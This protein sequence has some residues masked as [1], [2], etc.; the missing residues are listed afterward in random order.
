M[1][2][3]TAI[4][5]A[6][7]HR[8]GTSALA[9]ALN[10]LGIP[11]GSRLLESGP[12]N[13]KGYWEHR[14]IVV[15]HERLLAA[16]G[17]RWDDVRAL[18][19]GWLSS[20]PARRAAAAIT[21]IIERDFAGIPLWAV[22]DPRL[23]RVLPLWFEVLDK[24]GTRPMVLFMVRDP[25]EVSASIA[26]RNLWA[27]PIGEILWLRYVTES[28]EHSHRVP[29]S[30]VT[31]DALLADPAV[32]LS[33]VLSE[34]GLRPKATDS[35]ANESLGQ[36]VDIADRHHVHLNAA[37]PCTRFGIIAKRVYDLLVEVAQDR[38]DWSAVTRA[39]AGF[40]REWQAQHEV[41]EAFGGMAA[42][43]HTDFQ[44]AEVRIARLE[45]DLTAQI[46]WSD[47]AKTAHEAMQAENAELS[48][49][50]TAQIRW[51]EEAQARQEA[52]H[53]ENAELSSKL[54]AQIRWSEEAQARQEALQAADAELARAKE[55]AT[56]TQEALTAKLAAA[57]GD[58]ERLDA[59]LARAKEEATRTQEALT[60]KL[61]VATGDRERLDAELARA[62]AE[63]TQVQEALTAKL[64]AVMGDRERLDA[65]L[66]QT[67]AEKTSLAEAIAAIHA[68]P[69]WKM[70]RPLRAISRFLGRSSHT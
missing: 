32:T 37:V 1:S 58:R 19:D 31:F 56:R 35:V 24:L 61:V 47:E 44:D 43:L 39:G 41:L 52:L 48:S 65:E 5:V 42:K 70:T 25:G 68:S 36:F 40:A 18:P 6:G 59:E 29:R 27:P 49:K 66:A 33:N 11:L 54:I 62:K 63:A 38:G 15:V 57:T 53:A 45:S 28:L 4:L 55:E 26:E 17:S 16:L 34:L 60:A 12:D 13:P 51:S 30:V 14:D 20:E 9:G 46:R 23:C 69:W 64:V 21:E 7:M 10:L 2:S 67:T 22:K 8:S 50:L 3:N